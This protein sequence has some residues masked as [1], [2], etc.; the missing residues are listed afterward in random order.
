MPGSL[1]VAD[2]PETNRTHPVDMCLMA[3]QLQ[4]TI[5]KKNQ[6]REL[7]RLK[8][9]QMRIGINTGS[10]IAGVVGT[11]HYTYDVWGSTVNLAARLEQICV[12]GEI[13]ISPST[14]H[15]VENLF[16]TEP[17]GSIEVKNTGSVDV[18]SLLWIKPEYSSDEDGCTPN[19]AFWK[20]TGMES[21]SR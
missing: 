21:G 16:E 8:P 15:Y 13:S 6:Q 1:C 20:K 5:R 11:R 10:V 2:I 17:K 12:A 3:L 14:V 9:W 7:M 19:D 4:R 18:H